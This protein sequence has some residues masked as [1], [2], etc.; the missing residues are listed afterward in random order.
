[1]LYSYKWADWTSFDFLIFCTTW[2]IFKC[3]TRGCLG[4]DKL[5]LNLLWLFHWSHQNRPTIISFHKNQVQTQT[6]T[7]DIYIKTDMVNTPG[8]WTTK[9]FLK[10]RKVFRLPTVRLVAHMWRKWLVAQVGNMFPWRGEKEVKLNVSNV[11]R[12]FKMLRLFR[13]TWKVK[14]P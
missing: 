13:K 5:T 4:N 7:R 12:C 10:H 8:T 14:T 1:M 9:N 3:C 6:F 2:S 11:I